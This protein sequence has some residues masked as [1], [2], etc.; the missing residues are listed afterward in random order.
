MSELSLYRLNQDL[1]S[2]ANNSIATISV[3]GLMA[4]ADKIKLD[5]I[6]IN[7]NNYSLPTSSATILG[8]VKIGTG[9]DVDGLGSISVSVATISKNGLLSATDK[10][11]LDGLSNYSLPKA[12]ATTLGGV[13]IGNGVSIDAA[14]K[15]SVSTTYAVVTTSTDGLMSAADKTKLDFLSNYSLPTASASTLGGVKI[16]TGITMSSGTISVPAATQVT[17]SVDGLMIAADKTKLDGIATNANNYSLPTAS[18]SILGGVKIGTGITLNTGV[19]SVPAATQ[20]TDGLMISADKTKLDG[21]SNY[22][23]PTASASVLGGVKIGT[24]IT[25]NTG[26]I[27]IP[28]ATQSVDGLMSYGDKTKLDK[29]ANVRMNYGETAPVSPVIGQEIWFD[30]S[31]M[32]IKVYTA[33]GWVAFGAALA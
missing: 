1:Q 5:S 27:S 31:E 15:I 3:N 25:L 30:T 7:A 19:I 26:V 32:L 23:L 9:I 22:N 14:G 18:A 28:E 4:A 24:G 33:T 2:K 13:M 10:T 21:L 16:G 8:G 11:K 20:S 29:I 6:A 12:S 17:T